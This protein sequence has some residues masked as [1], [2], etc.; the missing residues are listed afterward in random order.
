MVPYLWWTDLDE[1]HM[2]LE[3]RD[4]EFLSFLECQMVLSTIAYTR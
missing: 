4:L 1:K 3:K 2:I